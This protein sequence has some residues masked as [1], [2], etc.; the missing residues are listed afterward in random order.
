MALCN[1][2][3]I[4]QFVRGPLRIERVQNKQSERWDCTEVAMRLEAP[5]TSADRQGCDTGSRE[6]G[7]EG[8]RSMIYRTTDASAGSACGHVDPDLRLIDRR[9]IT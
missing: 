9:G 7:D 2:R 3:R 8:L 1:G 5:M 6:T 4:S